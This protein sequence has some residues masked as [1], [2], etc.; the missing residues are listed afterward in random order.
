ME[1]LTTSFKN[2]QVRE[3]Y[4]GSLRKHLKA[5]EFY[6]SGSVV[7]DWIGGY[8]I[9]FNRKPFQ[10]FVPSTKINSSEMSQFTQAIHELQNVGAIEKCKHESGE[11]ISSFFLRK[12][13]NGKKRFILNLKSLNQFITAPHFKLEDNKVAQNVILKN[14]F[15]AKIDLKDAYFFV[16]VSNKYKKYLRFK[17]KNTL[18]QF[19]CIPFGLN[20]AP[21]LFTKI[22]RPI[23]K[24]LRNEG[25]QCIVY[26]DDWLVM[27]K[28]EIECRGSLTKICSVLNQLGFLINVEKSL[29]I[30]SKEC[31]FL[32]FTYN[33]SDMTIRL[34]DEKRNKL[35]INISKFSRKK[36]SKIREFAKFLGQ[37]V[38]A[39]PAVKYGWLY[40]KNFEREKQIALIKNDMCYDAK[41]T[42]SS[43]LTVDFKWWLQNVK[44]SIQTF[45]AKSFSLEIFCDA[46]TTGWGGFSNGKKAHGFWRSGENK[47]HINL[48]ELKAIA[49]SLKCF[50]RNK[51]NIN[52]LLRSDNITA[53]ASINRMGSVRFPNLNKEARI[54][55]QFCEK[56]NLFIYATY[57]Q[58]K[59][60]TIADKESRIKSIETEYEL[61]E[62]AYKKVV[63]FFGNPEI[64]LF[65][66]Y[67]NSKCN[68]FISWGPDPY[69]VSIDAFSI[70][71]DQFF[72]AFPPFSLVPKV[73]QKIVKNQAC[74]ILVV[75]YWPSQPWYPLFINM[76]TEKLILFRPN[77]NLLLSPFR[78]S[79][80]LWATLTLAV[81][82]LSGAHL[83]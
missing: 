12:K 54:I 16:P 76:L 69:S 74:G 66:S 39:S 57:I 24:K 50:A 62:I 40:I 41:I 5:W 67:T 49:Y 51:Q 28:T 22:F 82:R 20:I 56:R 29:L 35:L 30:P 38:S 79:H 55:W 6:T 60:N 34:P 7:L 21:Y 26:L 17:F 14:Y 68:K 75:P 37:L 47:L 71:W 65:A 43:K 19:T 1:T 52:I 78:E 73:L 59:K 61:S 13:P 80:P 23:I 31:T 4:A 8:K 10:K 9:P 70:N 64:D 11:F 63:S 58:S 3:K 53:I 48:L 45:G 77:K 81:G 72:Y 2:K 42:L 36:S 15:L 83:K 18:W 27:G 44:T 25:I 32:G 46:S 33:T